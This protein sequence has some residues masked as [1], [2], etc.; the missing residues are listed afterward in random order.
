MNNK[1]SNCCVIIVTFNGMQWIEKCISSLQSSSHPSDIL[2][3]DNHSN[4]G[5]VRFLK[6]RK[7]IHLIENDENIGFGKA[8]N[9]GL[10]YA[11][12][13]GYSHFFL[14]NQDAW[15]ETD[16]IELLIEE[17]S[18]DPNFGI[19]SPVHFNGEGTALDPGF[20][21]F[22]KMR[23]SSGF[24]EDHLKNRLSGI[25]NVSFVNAAAWMIS[26]E[27]IS[28][29]GLFHPLFT[30]YGED[31]NYIHRVVVNNYNVGVV[32]STRIYH[33]RAARFKKRVDPKTKFQSMVLMAYLNPLKERS[34]FSVWL[35]SIWNLIK[36]TP[37]W[38]FLP[39]LRFYWWGILQHA[40]IDKI[41]ER[42]GSKD[43]NPLKS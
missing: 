29:V 38:Y 35:I 23:K 42:F 21:R 6:D 12:R 28:K 8:N 1:R 9:I 7:D 19:L 22:M 15:V 43:Y 5:S 4:D 36:L 11:Y 24:Y 20:R 25:Y 3:V 41:V 33:D 14:L 39:N 16:T 32:S 30:H 26:R 40:R 17:Q 31:D 2:V 27:C 10:E 37:F 18:K 13:A 34:S